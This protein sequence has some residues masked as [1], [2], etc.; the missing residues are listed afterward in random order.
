MPDKRIGRRIGCGPRGGRVDTGGRGGQYDQG[1]VIR[2]GHQTRRPL[3]LALRLGAQGI[4]RGMQGVGRARRGVAG[5]LVGGLFD[6]RRRAVWFIVEIGRRLGAQ[7]AGVAP[8]PLQ[9]RARD[10][11]WRRLGH[12]VTIAISAA[13]HGQRQ[14]LVARPARGARQNM[15]VAHRAVG[16]GGQ[17]APQPIKNVERRF[18]RR[19]AARAD[20][21]EGQGPGP[22]LA[23]STASSAPSSAGGGDR[24]N[25][26]APSS[27]I[28]A[29]SAS[30][31]ASA[32]ARSRLL[33]RR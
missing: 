19:S 12:G 1:A 10:I 24:R 31:S 23:A 33:A 13:R 17:P 15:D 20:M 25:G 27:T 22:A 2:A 7:E 29:A 8:R 5:D 21:A 28:R 30:G 6:Q 11:I 16:A 14:D 32:R 4:G 9:K 3:R 18:P 26:S